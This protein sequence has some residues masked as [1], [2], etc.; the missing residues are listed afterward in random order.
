[1]PKAAK[2]TF[3]ARGLILLLLAISV[4]SAD[5]ALTSA[6]QYLDAGEL[7]N[8]VIVL[9]EHLQTAPDDPAAHLLLGQVY[10]A[11]YL[12][13]AAEAELTRAVTLGIPAQDTA[14]DLALARLRQGDLAR[15]LDAAAVVD[16]ELPAPVRAERLAIQA[17]ARVAMDQSDAAA[18]LLAQALELDPTNASA[19]FEQSRLLRGNGLEQRA[20]T[21][22]DR[23]LAAHPGSGRLLIAQAEV[24]RDEGRPDDADA[25]LTRAGEDGRYRW[26]ALYQ[27]AL[28]HIV[29]ERYQD[30]ANDIAAAR[31]LHPGFPGLDYAEGWLQQSVGQD[32]LAMDA[33][34]RFLA[35]APSSASVS[36]RAARSA[37]RLGDYE[38]ARE[39]LRQHL[40]LAPDSTPGK[41]LLA[42]V[43]A[44]QGDLTTAERTLRPFAEAEEPEPAALKALA[45]VKQR[46]GDTEAAIALLKP[47]LRMVI[48][49]NG[50]RI[51]LGALLADAGEHAAARRTLASA[52]AAAPDSLDVRIEQIAA[53]IKAEQPERALALSE[54]LLAEHP[55]APRA[56][57]AR[58]AAL[59]ANADIAA[60]RAALEQAL[61]LDPG[62]TE[63]ALKLA[64]LDSAEGNRDQARR[65]YEAILQQDP[66]QHQAILRLAQLDV[67]A[68]DAQAGLARLEGALASDPGSADLRLNLVNGYLEAGRLEDA[69]AL[70]SA[71]PPAAAE[72]PGIVRL[73]GLIASAQGH[74]FAA[75]EYFERLADLRPDAVAPRYLLARAYA[76]VDNATAMREH[77]L[78]GFR[79]DPDHPLAVPALNQ[80]LA[81]LKDPAEQARLLTALAEL[82]PNSP[83]LRLAEARTK[84]QA[85]ET[86]AAL[87]IF[88]ALHRSAPD[89]PALLQR[90]GRRPAARRPARSGHADRRGLA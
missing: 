60:A 74:Q 29:R 46:Q 49:D 81:T 35:V 83:A 88:A 79:Q 37:M 90:P 45:Q 65:R 31:R 75:A 63:A 4:A 43:A 18:M 19:L 62:F 68:G 14:T 44:A 87:T 8:A 61:A 89:D 7:H 30:A 32:G 21:L 5:T 86:D 56:L 48:D 28:A 25:L 41:L 76:A 22:L 84:E 38:Q 85:G 27:R 64:R 42:T 15:A 34:D 13:A 36:L 16:D 50:A 3:F 51:L 2:R 9:K 69:A 10:L 70:L 67:E 6:R 59:A 82:W 55:E 26:L 66:L 39:Y 57:S 40:A 17:A 73:Q 52:L 77:L 24:A 1:M 71:V 58:A 11:M 12:G 80:V 20:Q 72:H 23:A 33:F 47:Y 78:A 53:A 54:T